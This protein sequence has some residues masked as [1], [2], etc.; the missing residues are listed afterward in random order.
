MR[1][2][3][4]SLAFDG[5]G[6]VVCFVAS[7][8]LIG[9]LASG[10]V[11]SLSSAGGLGSFVQT[12]YIIN[13]KAIIT[14]ILAGQVKSIVADDTHQLAK[15]NSTPNPKTTAAQRRDNS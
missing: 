6:L 13:A 1:G 15:N 3:S 2:F 9:L 8:R 11:S 12:S 7:F 14:S 5:G 10:I 4:I